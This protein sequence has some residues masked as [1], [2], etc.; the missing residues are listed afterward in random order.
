MIRKGPRKRR[1]MINSVMVGKKTNY[2]NVLFVYEVLVCAFVFLKT[3]H[4]DNFTLDSSFSWKGSR[5]N[6][7]LKQHINKI[8]NFINGFLILTNG[9]R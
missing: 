9:G 3:F 2:H 7:R 8:F 6:L 5:I 4:G 1:F